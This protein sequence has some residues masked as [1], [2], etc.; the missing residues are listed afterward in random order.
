MFPVVMP[1][2]GRADIAFTKGEGVWLW[3]NDG[4]RYLDFAGGVAVNAFGHCYPPLVKVLQDQAATLWHCSNL[5]RVEGQE[6]VAE[7]LCALSFADTVFF[8]NSGL[9]A[10]ECAIKVARKYQHTIGNAERYRVLCAK[11]AF[12]GRS[13]ATLAAGGQAKH[14]AGFEPM[15]DGFDHVPFGDLNALDG[16]VTPQT[17]AILLEVVQGEGGVVPGDPAYFRAARDLADRHGLLLMI[18]EVQTGLGR[19]GTL[20]AYEQTGV[21]PDVLTL[22]KGLGSGFPVGA[23]LATAKAAQGMTPGSHGSTFGGNPLAMSVADKV[24]DLM[25]APGF[26]DH[27]QA[28][29]NLFRKGLDDLA[30]RYP[31][32][33]IHIRGMGLLLGIDYKGDRAAFI[34]ALRRNGLLTVGAGDTVVR[35]APPLIITDADVAKALDILAQTLDEVKE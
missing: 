27:V 16:A 6:R 31:A 20:F 17:A 2:Y 33:V 8:C 35:F 15:V 18:D 5:Y 3:G 21:V 1:T 26:L 7:K 30:V 24:L 23:C 22:A 11:G 25:T 28:M 14:L 13:L 32:S 9:E 29:G 19:T 10:N 12:H 4:R 34:S